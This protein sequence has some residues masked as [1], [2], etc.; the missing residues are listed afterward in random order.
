MILLRKK[1]QKSYKR[2]VKKLANLSWEDS[3][4]IF[5]K[6]AYSI[7]LLLVDFEQTSNH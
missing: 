3:E 5:R 2:F 4:R 7:Q 6:K 1:I